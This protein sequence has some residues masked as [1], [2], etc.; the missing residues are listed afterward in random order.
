MV[1]LKLMFRYFSG[2]LL[3]F[4]ACSSY[5]Q[6]LDLKRKTSHYIDVNKVEKTDVFEI[7]DGILSLQYQDNFG[8]SK[9]FELKVYTWQMKPAA[10]FSLDKSFGLNNYNIDLNNNFA[11]EADMSYLCQLKNENGDLYEWYIRASSKKTPDLTL[12]IIVNPLQLNCKGIDGNLVEFFGLVSDGRPPFTIRWYVMNS[13]KSDFLYQ[14]KEETVKELG[15]TAAIQ[16]DKA[17]SY[18]VVFDVTDACGL[19]GRK[20]VF[21]QCDDTKK[22]V[23]TLFVEPLPNV[24]TV[25]NTFTN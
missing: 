21:M 1:S 22:G 9:D 2:V 15:K 24:P 5:A 18:Y 19:T 8:Q 25:K 7:V 4:F 23:N 13:A 14:P 12:S 3:L 20:M 16:V 6:E 17:P 11:L 10:I